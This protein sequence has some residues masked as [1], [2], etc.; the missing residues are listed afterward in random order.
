MIHGLER[1]PSKEARVALKLEFLFWT[2]RGR[3]DVK[4]ILD[5]PTYLY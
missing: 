1:A 4:M 5:P 3:L 2:I